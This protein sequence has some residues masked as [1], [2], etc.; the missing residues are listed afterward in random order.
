MQLPGSGDA[1]LQGCAATEV[2]GTLVAE[3]CRLSGR[4]YGPGEL[5][6]FSLLTRD[7]GAEVGQEGRSIPL[8]LQLPPLS[9]G[10]FGAVSMRLLLKH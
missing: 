10:R 9:L 1:V 4:K 3:A 7:A 6:R 5:G 8:R 2:L